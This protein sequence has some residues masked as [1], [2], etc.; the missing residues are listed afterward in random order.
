M[1]DTIINVTGTTADD[2]ATLLEENFEE[3]VFSEQKNDNTIMLHG[4][5]WY[6]FISDDQYS[7][8]SSNGN[9][10][11]QCLVLRHS[12]GGSSLKLG[13]TITPPVNAPQ[14][15]SFVARVQNWA[16]YISAMPF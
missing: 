1:C 12:G 2:Q 3:Y 9:A 15:I 16:R 5:E 4:K 8:G 10:L 13:Y 11:N 7:S 14:S 6:F